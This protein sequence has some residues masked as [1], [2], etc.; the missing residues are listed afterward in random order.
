[1]ELVVTAPQL[2]ALSPTTLQSSAALRRIAAW[3]VAAPVAAGIDAAL[4]DALGIDGLSVAALLARGAG[5]VGGGAHWLVADPVSLVA[6]RDDVVVVARVD[7][8]EPA[9][10][11]RAVALLDAHF[12][13]DGMRVVAVRPGRWL[14]QLRD[15]PRSTFDSTDVALG[16]SMHAHRPRGQDA[17]RFERY[18][19]EIQMLLHDAPENDARERA[20][21]PPMNGLW[22]W[23]G[24]PRV[25]AD[26]AR[27]GID[28]FATDGAAGDLARGIALASGGAVRPLGTRLQPSA[29]DNATT[30]V[31]LPPI[32]PGSFAQSDAGW[33]APATEALAG[34]AITRLTLLADG[35]GT[36]QWTVSPPSW[37]R[38]LHARFAASRF[39][40]TA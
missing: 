29:H 14:L 2:L 11:A 34:R 25:S 13:V 32:T 24:A 39:G 28:A 7:D 31:A 19:N 8:A 1:M 35:A 21:L 27:A 3:G 10:I 33:L 16:G 4:V 23:D 5:L 36:R 37:Q 38:R 9:F 12:A 20:G 17:R 15:A 40:V 30:L 6:G 18:A 22:L 26:V